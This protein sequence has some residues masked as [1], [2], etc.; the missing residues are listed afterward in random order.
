MGSVMKIGVV[1]LYGLLA[2][3]CVRMLRKRKPLPIADA[4]GEVGRPTWLEIILFSAMGVIVAIMSLTTLLTPWPAALFC[5][6]LSASLTDLMLRTL[7]RRVQWGADGFAYRDG[8]G[9]LHICAWQDVLGGERTWM[10][11]GRAEVQVTF[12]HTREFS[13]TVQEKQG[14]AFLAEVE[15]RCGRLQPVR[16]LRGPWHGR[17]M[18]ME[19]YEEDNATSLLFGIGL[20]AA[21][22]MVPW[23]LVLAVPSLAWSLLRRCLSGKDNVPRWLVRILFAGGNYHF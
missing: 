16:P 5:W 4:L 13:L 18:D 17:I 14:A 10:R 8:R 3:H 23:A 6:S 1:A 21:G 20:L 9:G 19:Q 12:L 7:L 2:A 11:R 15:R 22:V